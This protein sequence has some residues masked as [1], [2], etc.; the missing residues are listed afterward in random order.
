MADACG[1]PVFA[2]P[3]EAT[4]YGN[5]GLQLMAAGELSHPGQIR[6][7]VRASEEIRIFE[8]R[9]HERWEEIRQR[10]GESLKMTDI[11]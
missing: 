7:L 4:V 6:D 8:P 3:V 11:R 2:G 9:D 10:F 5:L 1:L